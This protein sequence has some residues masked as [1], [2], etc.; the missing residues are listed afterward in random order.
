MAEKP[1]QKTEAR[2]EVFDMETPDGKELV[3]VTANLDTG[4]RAYGE[5]RPKK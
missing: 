2:V 5:P 3:E 4:D 1:A